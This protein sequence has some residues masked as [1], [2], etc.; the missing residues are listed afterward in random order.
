VDL[1]AEQGGNCVLTEP[2]STVVKHGVTIQGPLNLPSAM[3]PQASQLYSKNITSFVSAVMKDAKLSLS[4]DDEL[5]K[6]TMVVNRGAIVNPQ[7][8]AALGESAPQ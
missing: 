2:G 8:K 6:G 3:A 5:V 4:T 7:V 1:A